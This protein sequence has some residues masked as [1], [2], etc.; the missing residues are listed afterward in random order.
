MED[1]L[2]RMGGKTCWNLREGGNREKR[3]QEAMPYWRSEFM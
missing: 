3:W 2:G 1:G